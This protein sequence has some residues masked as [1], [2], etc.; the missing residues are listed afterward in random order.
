MIIF[1]ES[2][3]HLEFYFLIKKVQKRAYVSIHMANVGWKEI[4]QLN[5]IDAAKSPE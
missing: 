5:A 3:K 2:I 4:D 1:F